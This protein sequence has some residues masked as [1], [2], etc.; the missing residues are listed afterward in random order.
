MEPCYYQGWLGSVQEASTA[1]SLVA[2][3]EVEMGMAEKALDMPVVTSSYDIRAA[4]RRGPLGALSQGGGDPVWL[5]PLV[6][7]AE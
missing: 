6:D 4:G 2:R 5:R 7:V 3:Y 1:A